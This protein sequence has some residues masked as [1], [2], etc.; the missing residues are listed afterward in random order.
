MPTPDIGARTRDGHVLYIMLTEKLL[1]HPSA[2]QV[3]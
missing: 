1:K 3:E 2:F